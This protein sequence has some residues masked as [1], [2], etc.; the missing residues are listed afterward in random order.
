MGNKSSKSKPKPK[1][2]PPPP[3]PLYRMR[4]FGSSSDMFAFDQQAQSEAAAQIQRD[5]QAGLDANQQKIDDAKAEADRNEL[6]NK[7][8]LAAEVK[9][10]ARLAAEESARLAKIEEDKRA[11]EQ[12]AK[13]RIAEAKS[14]REAEELRIAAAKALVIFQ[15]TVADSHTTTVANISTRFYDLKTSYMTSFDKIQNILVDTIKIRDVITN[16]LN[17][18][19][20]VGVGAYLADM[21]TNTISIT[22]ASNVCIDIYNAM[23]SIKQSIANIIPDIDILSD[24][25]LSNHVKTIE[26]TNRKSVETVEDEIDETTDTIPTINQTLKDM[27]DAYDNIK[28]IITDMILANNNKIN[29]NQNTI[30]STVTKFVEE[31]AS[32]AS[33]GFQQQ[34]QPYHYRT[35]NIRS[36]QMVKPTQ[37]SAAKSMPYQFRGSN[38]PIIGYHANDM[39]YSNYK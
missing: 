30:T 26:D 37:P 35:N 22:T 16:S 13:R 15:T 1:P 8:R 12:E 25:T 34:P 39:S 28:L 4:G 21:K 36:P 5:I 24:T 33:E 38:T 27:D 20:Y 14:A 19:D 18:R 31:S 29:N 32:E 7:K 6:E 11:D 3:P 10:A 9:E 2:I 23:Q 17:T